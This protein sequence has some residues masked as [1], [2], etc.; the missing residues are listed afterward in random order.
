MNS[1]YN[2]ITIYYPGARV[3]GISIALIPLILSVS[4]TET[5]KSEWIGIGIFPA[6]KSVTLVTNPF[7]PG[8]TTSSSSGKLIVKSRSLISYLSK[9]LVDPPGCSIMN[10]KDPLSPTLPQKTFALPGY[11][12]L[13]SQPCE[14]PL[15]S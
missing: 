13:P 12:F 15:R 2:G 9:Y 11:P 5:I 14:P 6:F 3:L 1:S 10:S 8:S 7:S 4:T